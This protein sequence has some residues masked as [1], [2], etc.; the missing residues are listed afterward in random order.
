[1]KKKRVF[2]FIVMLIMLSCMAVLIYGRINYPAAP[3]R[4]VDGKFLDKQKREHSAEEFRAFKIWE[5][6]SFGF[7]MS[8]LA[9]GIIIAVVNEVSKVKN[10]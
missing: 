6:A 10:Q 2:D 7:L 5:A 1:M 3:Y 9:G 4:E 8:S